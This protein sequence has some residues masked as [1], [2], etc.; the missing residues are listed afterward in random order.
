M[1]PPNAPA[2]TTSVFMNPPRVA[3]SDF[4]AIR[5]LPRCVRPPGSPRSVE[6]HYPL[7]YFAANAPAVDFSCP[8]AEAPVAACSMR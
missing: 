1:I 7:G 3:F 6:S 2:P 5:R 4:P 8:A